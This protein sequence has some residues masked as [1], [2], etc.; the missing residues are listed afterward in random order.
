M[1]INRRLRQLLVKQDFC[2]HWCGLRLVSPYR[3]EHCHRATVDHVIP[4][5]KGGTD[6]RD[7]RVA[8]CFACNQAKGD[9]LP[10]EWSPVLPARARAALAY[11]AG[12][13]LSSHTIDI[14]R[15]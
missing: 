4:R 12:S 10:A 8:A 9:K 14:A 13:A 7:N 1:R 11:A 6:T 3:R 15:E 2:C 5:A